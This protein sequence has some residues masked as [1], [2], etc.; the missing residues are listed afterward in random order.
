MKL[1]YREIRREIRIRQTRIKQ[2]RGG[3]KED[4]R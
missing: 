4:E 3:V 1:L 2:E